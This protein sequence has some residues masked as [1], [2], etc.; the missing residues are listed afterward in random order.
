[1]ASPCRNYGQPCT[2]HHSRPQHSWELSQGPR[3]RG[4]EAYLSCPGLASSHLWIPSLLLTT[5][6]QGPHHHP[7]GRT[8]RRRAQNERLFQNYPSHTPPLSHC[9]SPDP[10]YHSKTHRQLQITHS[11]P[12]PLFPNPYHHP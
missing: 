11:T 6:H 2:L 5:T 10:P 12:P 9:H 1:M 8:E 3:L 7:S 4:L